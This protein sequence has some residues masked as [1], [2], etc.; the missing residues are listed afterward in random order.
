MNFDA[1]LS[2]YMFPAL[3]EYLAI[4]EL[5]G[6]VSYDALYLKRYKY[7]PTDR[8]SVDITDG[9]Y[10]RRSATTEGKT[11]LQDPEQVVTLIAHAANER[12]LNR[13]N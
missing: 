4:A 9:T 7:L 12:K 13:F 10:F 11:L 3:P 2:N 6:F 8:V 1:I 5:H